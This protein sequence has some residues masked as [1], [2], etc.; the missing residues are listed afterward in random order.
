VHR[1]WPKAHNK[2]PR[3]GHA[4][5]GRQA[6]RQALR[7]RRRSRPPAVDG[8]PPKAKLP[9]QCVPLMGRLPWFVHRPAGR[10]KPVDALSLRSAHALPSRNA[11]RKRPQGTGVL[12]FSTVLTAIPSCNPISLVPT[13]DRR[14]RS[15]STVRQ[16][17]RQLLNGRFEPPR[18]TP[19]GGPSPPAQPP[20]PPAS[21][22]SMIFARRQHRPAANFRRLILI[23]RKAAA[24][25]FGE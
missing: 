15:K 12:F 7:D 6:T 19:G 1:V 23:Q 24:R 17:R 20:G 14:L 13:A 18:P 5:V 10:S 9:L 16:P 21:A 2:T 8:A 3:P 11:A 22:N 25:Q 4:R